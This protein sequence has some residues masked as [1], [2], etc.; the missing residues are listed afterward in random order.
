MSNN[1][2]FCRFSIKTLQL[3]TFYRVLKYNVI[4]MNKYKT[5]DRNYELYPD[6]EIVPVENLK[7][8]DSNLA[9]TE[10]T[11]KPERRATSD[12]FKAQKSQETD[13]TELDLPDSPVIS[14]DVESEKIDD[15][16]DIIINESV[17][18]QPQKRRGKDKIKRNGGRPP[19]EKQLAN[20]AKAREARRISQIRKK[21]EKIL[22]T[23][24]DK[25]KK[26]REDAIDAANV[27]HDAQELQAFRD[28]KKDK[29]A[30]ARKK[31]VVEFIEEKQA[32]ASQ[33]MINNFD[34]FCNYMDRY[35][36][37]KIN[38]NKEAREQVHPNKMINKHLLPRA[39]V[40]PNQ[41]NEVAEIVQQPRRRNI[42]D[43]LYA[44]NMLRAT[45]RNNY[46]NQFG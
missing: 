38:K 1:R 6:I 16:A 44:V 29:H 37:N 30:T 11:P 42:R 39:P 46:K 33:S 21:S 22:K 17:I 36:S 45:N 15:T 10:P 24:A 43:P 26:D 31:K 9:T 41:K 2:L 8:K 28:K 13:N 25:R 4:L 14:E 40:V 27:L 5:P 32:M 35:E 19:S 7:K 34:T 12:I 18:K 23:A 3:I 20:L